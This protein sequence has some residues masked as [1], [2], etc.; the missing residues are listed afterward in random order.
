MSRT[1]VSISGNRRAVP[2]S[3]K[4]RHLRAIGGRLTR[5]GLDWLQGPA[6]D[7]ASTRPRIV[8]TIRPDPPEAVVEP[9]IIGLSQK[10]VD[11]HN[12]KR[13]KSHG[14]GPLM[15]VA[16]MNITIEP[17]VAGS[18]RIAEEVVHGSSEREFG[19]S[20]KQVN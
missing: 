13:L 20:G 10:L 2:K 6:A 3:V 12:A 16:R 7:L 17:P 1:P 5:D 11:P 18:T 8:K 15:A 4:V 9:P 14:T 19:G